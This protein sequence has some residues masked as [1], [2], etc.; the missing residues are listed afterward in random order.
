MT[1][2]IPSHAAWFA[3]DDV[4]DIERRALPE[5]FGSGTAL[6]T[7]E[8]YK[9]ARNF[10][11]SMYREQPSLYLSVTECRRHLA[12]DV[13]AVMRLHQ[14]LEHWGLI[15]YLAQRPHGSGSSDGSV[16]LDGP[17]A[18]AVAATAPHVRLSLTP[19]GSGLSTRPNLY[20]TAAANGS[21]GSSATS[22]APAEEK[23][24]SNESVLAL[25]EGIEQAA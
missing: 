7:S 25:L 22:T 14:F 3:V 1:T 19:G 4:H 6:K 17:A 2:T 21:A 10:I 16:V 13:S 18:A 9:Q 24:W 5:Y 11:V 8:S 12:L 15:N 23:E 20:S